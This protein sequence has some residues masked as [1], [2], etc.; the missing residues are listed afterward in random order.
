MLNNNLNS[1]T[2][3]VKPKF[4]QAKDS[5]VNNYKIELIELF[6]VAD[7][8]K[9]AAKFAKSYTEAVRGYS[10]KL[11]SDKR[12][13][14]AVRDGKEMGFISIRDNTELLKITIDGGAWSIGTAYVKPAYR[15]CGVMKQ[16]IE[17]CVSDHN[18]KMIHIEE[19]RYLNCHSYY[20][21]LGFVK[22]ERATLN[23]FDELG[24]A[25][26]LSFVASA[27]KQLSIPMPTAA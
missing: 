12:Y 11:D 7:K 26:H 3:F 21:K 9:W 18:V 27:Q 10:K 16:M 1:V 14:V 5:K 6:K 17:L 20:T 19:Y 4:N 22:F 2:S 13:F 8:K 23:P 24:Y 25:Y 15:H